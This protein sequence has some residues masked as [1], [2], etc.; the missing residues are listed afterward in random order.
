MGQEDNFNKILR[1]KLEQ[2]EVANDRIEEHWQLYQQ[3]K[4]DNGFAWWIAGGIAILT[5]ILLL[6]MFMALPKRATEPVKPVLGLPLDKTR[7]VE[8]PSSLPENGQHNTTMQMEPSKR[9]DVKKSPTP[10]NI[11]TEKSSSSGIST[12]EKPEEKKIVPGIIEQ[13]P[14]EPP[15]Q[16]PHDNPEPQVQQELPKDTL[17]KEK[18]KVDIIW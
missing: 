14:S 8:K 13:K 7:S 11:A 3:Q 5:A 16:Y 17:Q 9:P 18:Q 15:A 6:W 4:P 10:I 1:Q 12:E 2:L